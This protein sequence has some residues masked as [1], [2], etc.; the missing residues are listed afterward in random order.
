MVDIWISEKAI[1]EAS[2]QE[3]ILEYNSIL[4]VQHNVTNVLISSRM[5]ITMLRHNENNSVRSA[6]CT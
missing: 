5:F 1:K 3:K 4:K 2:I 6:V